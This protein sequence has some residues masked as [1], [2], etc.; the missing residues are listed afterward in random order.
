[1]TG[2]TV[3]EWVRLLEKTRFENVTATTG[4]DN[5]FSSDVPEDRIA[6]PLA[7]WLTDTSGA[8]NTVDIQKVEEDD[9]T[10][11]LHMNFNLGPNESVVISMEELGAILPRFEGDTNLEL[12]A[13]ANNV[14]AT[15]IYV[16]NVEI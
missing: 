14:E 7:I 4:G 2:L 13:G 9:T 12:T 8:A 11:D 6:I 15:L 5:V 16:Y 1:M 3:D 10:T